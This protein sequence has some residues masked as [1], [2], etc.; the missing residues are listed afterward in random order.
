MIAHVEMT[1]P[2]TK[3]VDTPTPTNNNFISIELWKMT[4]IYQIKMH[5]IEGLLFIFEEVN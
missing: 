2:K 5:L 3:R 1:P 4:A